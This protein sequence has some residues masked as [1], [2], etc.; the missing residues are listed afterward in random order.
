MRKNINWVKTGKNLKLLRCD[1]LN[2]RKYICKEIKTEKEVCDG[3]SCENCRFDMDH[4]ISQAELGKVFGVT[5]SIVANWETG[6]TIPQI[7]DMLFYSEICRIPL[8]EILIF[9]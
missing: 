7:E 1:N 8:E 2:L 3:K 4:S 6:R 5:E 9:Y